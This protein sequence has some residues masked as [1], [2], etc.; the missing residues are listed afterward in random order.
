MKYLATF[1]ITLALVSLSSASA[2]AQAGRRSTE[3][4]QATYP[5][6][7]PVEPA[8][9]V[10]I[11]QDSQDETI[12]QCLDTSQSP[13][14]ASAEAATSEEIFSGK[15]VTTK[16]QI[17]SK[18]EPAYTREARRN[19][20]SGRVALKIVLSSAA[21]VTS[22]KV[23]R[24]LP[25]GLTE[26]AVKAACGIRFKPATKDDRPVAQYLIVEYGFATNL[27]YGSR[28]RPPSFPPR[29]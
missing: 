17:L 15:D 12:Y 28:S 5:V 6:R 21:R 18:P 1:V 8:Q 2:G 4:P 19:G 25:D 11:K 16:A 9:N 29:P 14:T 3:T 22:A 13:D 27:P 26:S 7:L 23:I 10:K 24:G 20:T